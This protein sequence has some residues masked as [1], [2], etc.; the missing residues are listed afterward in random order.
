[1]CGIAGI[2]HTAPGAAP[3]RAVLT[4]MVDALRHRGPDDAGL[5]VDGE[6]GLGHARLEILD[7]AGGRQPM[8]LPDALFSITYNGE[9]FNY[10]ELRADMETRGQRFE[11]A[12]D[13]EVVLRRFAQRGPA[14][15]GDF[16]GQWAF[17]VWDGRRR[18]LFLA[19]DRLGILPLYYASVDGAFLFAS[20]V[21]ALLRHPAVPAALDLEALDQLFTFWHPVGGRTLFRGI[22][23]VP[24]GCWLQVRDGRVT[25]H[26]Y[27]DLPLGESPH[28]GSREELAARLRD[29]LIDAVRIRLRA[30]VPV[31]AYLSGGLDSTAV[32]ALVRRFTDTPIR[33]FSVTFEDPDYDESTFQ[34]EACR[35]LGTEHSTIACATESIGQ[36]FPEVVWHAEK[37]VLRTAPAPL[38][39][40]SRHVRESGYKVV[41]TGEGAD[42]LLGGYDIF[43]EAKI[44][45]FWAAQPQSRWRPRLLDRLYP[46]LAEFQR[47]SPALRQRFFRIDA[48]AAKDPF[49][50][51]LPRW[52]MTA[53]LKLFLSEPVR[54]E[55]WN[56]RATDE[57][58]ASLP[59]GFS[60]WGGFA[61]AQ[62]LES[63]GL[64]PGYILSSQGDRMLMAHS[65][66][67]RFPFL[68]HR[69]AEFACRLPARLKMR[70]LDEKH[71]L[72]AAVG[73]LVPPAVRARPK[74]PYRAPD[75]T[76]FFRADG[77]PLPFVRA[78]LDPALLERFGIFQ[79]EAVAALVRKARLGRISGARDNMALVAVL[80]TQIL[81]DRFIDRR[82][83]T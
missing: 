42:E 49:F 75:A 79:P 6:V 80:S 25:I 65:V 82:E 7:P 63:T 55:L 17:A 51:H 72:K 56:Y 53:G 23:E 73:D 26:R 61:R 2:L 13:T 40:L 18:E 24:P 46:Y 12:S 29:L 81:V 9:V 14:C 15:L 5:F 32:A 50:S 41:L 60:G 74:Q 28:R 67:G 58:S 30:D 77:E 16:N 22:R 68:D 47:L 64:L 45:R 54:A 20:E 34:Q 8:S 57:L 38:F 66:E 39:V 69:V 31:G 48:E 21:K 70:G 36:H 35:H 33:T 4:R 37:P 1:M 83:R 27:W 76:S 59:A 78:L 11:T 62:Y 3:D 44:R 10:V 43:K 71:L 52:D 19:R